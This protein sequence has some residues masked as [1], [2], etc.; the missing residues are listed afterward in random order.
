MPPKPASKPSKK[1]AEPLP[2]NPFSGAPL[3]GFAKFAAE[4]TGVRL[5]KPVSNGQRMKGF[6]LRPTREQRALAAAGGLFGLPQFKGW[7]LEE[8]ARLVGEVERR[9]YRSV[10]SREKIAKEMSGDRALAEKLGLKELAPKGLKLSGSLVGA[11]EEMTGARADWALRA[12]SVVSPRL[13]KLIFRQFDRLGVGASVMIA[14]RYG[15]GSRSYKSLRANLCKEWA[16]LNKGR[17][18]LYRADIRRSVPSFV[19]I[20]WKLQNY[21]S[22]LIERIALEEALEGESISSGELHR[23]FVGNKNYLRMAMETDYWKE[24]EAKH[25][26]PDFN[27]RVPFPEGFRKMLRAEGIRRKSDP[28]K[29]K[30]LE[31]RVRAVLKELDWSTK[32]F[33]DVAG[34]TGEPNEF[35]ELVNAAFNARFGEGTFSNKADEFIRRAARLDYGDKRIAKKKGWNYTSVGRHLSGRRALGRIK[36]H[37][38][39][40]APLGQVIRVLYKT[41][42]GLSP[43]RVTEQ[44]G[45]GRRTIAKM[46]GDEALIAEIKSRPMWDTAVRFYGERMDKNGN[47]IPLKK[48]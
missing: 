22:G 23:S 48:K 45:M 17:P 3:E 36:S 28:E 39:Y 4:Q 31:A 38:G 6:R 16:A 37:K 35:V 29:A 46:L 10:D 7:K 41:S 25:P 42:L 24:L 15:L 5:Q 21:P 19:R 32:S 11:I 1:P 13:K 18:R 27:K 47:I 12:K 43:T 9:L 44:E 40:D 33:N 20:V 34:Q 14:E 30:E 26:V 8:I 2:E